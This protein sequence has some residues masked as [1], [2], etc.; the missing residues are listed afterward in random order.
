VS[1]I[2]S[3]HQNDTF[4]RFLT[5]IAVHLLAIFQFEETIVLPLEA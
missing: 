5:D 1:C 3:T 2:W 4:W